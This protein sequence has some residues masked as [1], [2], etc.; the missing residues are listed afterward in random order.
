MR[1]KLVNSS[2]WTSICK[3]SGNA[4]LARFSRRPLIDW[5]GWLCIRSKTV[6]P[7]AR[8]I[9]LLKSSSRAWIFEDANALK[10]W[11]QKQKP[12]Q[13]DWALHSC[14]ASDTQRGILV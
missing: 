6:S 5:P 7:D 3:A 13:A 4:S 14:H 1:R 2:A 9:L 11:T 10:M 8:N 12:F